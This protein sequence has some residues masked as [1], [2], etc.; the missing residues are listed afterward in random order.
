MLRTVQI[1]IDDKSIVVG[2]LSDGDCLGG[3]VYR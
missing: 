2:N 1:G 3:E